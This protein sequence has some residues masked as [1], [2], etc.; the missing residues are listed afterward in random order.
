MALWRKD[1]CEFQFL[2]RQGSSSG[3][4]SKP[5]IISLWGQDNPTVP[6]FPFFIVFLG[7]NRCTLIRGFDPHPSVG[8][9]INFLASLDANP[10][11]FERCCRLG[12]GDNEAR[13]WVS[14]GTESPTGCRITNRFFFFFSGE[15]CNGFRAGLQGLAD[16]WGDGFLCFR[17]PFCYFRALQRGL[18]SWNIFPLLDGSIHHHFC[19]ELYQPLPLTKLGG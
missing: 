12:G 18:L 9:S 15:L 2:R 16:V 17:P 19:G 8:T 13:E 5:K 6:F 1:V 11:G 14:G 4:G 7:V 3:A 10:F